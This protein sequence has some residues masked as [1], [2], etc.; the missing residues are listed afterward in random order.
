MT[1]ISTALAINSDKTKGGFSHVEAGGNSRRSFGKRDCD[2]NDLVGHVSI[3]VSSCRWKWCLCENGGMESGGCRPRATGSSEVCTFR[4]TG[5]N[6]LAWRI[7]CITVTILFAMRWICQM[8]LY[9]LCCSVESNNNEEDNAPPPMW[10]R[11][12]NNKL[13][14]WLEVFVIRFILQVLG[15]TGAIWGISEVIKLRTNET[16]YIWR[17]GVLGVGLIFACRW[18]WQLGTLAR[19]KVESEQPDEETNAA[20]NSNDSDMALELLPGDHVLEETADAEWWLWYNRGTNL[21]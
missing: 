12:L 1:T 6:L 5:H 10:L 13:C 20:D 14:G 11:L 21:C 9:C 19:R 17:P 7:T 2:A 16:L 18:L 3:S 8:L 4:T 15:A